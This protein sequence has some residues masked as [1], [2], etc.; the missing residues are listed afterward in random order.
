MMPN[1]LSGRYRDGGGNT[2]VY[3]LLRGEEEEEQQ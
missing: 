1:K 2:S 3:S